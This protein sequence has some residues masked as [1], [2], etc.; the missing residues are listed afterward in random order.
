M[1]ARGTMSTEI[2]CTTSPATAEQQSRESLAPQSLILKEIELVQSEIAR[3]DNNCLTIRSWSLATWTA[4][5]AYGVEKQKPLIILAAL[6]TTF[7]FALIDVVHRRIQVRFILRSKDIEN[8]L[9][10]KNFSQY[11]Y[12]VH[13]T[14]D[15]KMNDSRFRTEALLIFKHPYYWLFYLVL[16]ICAA[17]CAIYTTQ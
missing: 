9:N 3:F 15:G 5:I 1:E 8:T 7:S 14:A 17:G 10:S 2:E 4:V 13:R 16:M 11:Q 12:A 6:V